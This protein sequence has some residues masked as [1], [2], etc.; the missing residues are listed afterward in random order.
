LANQVTSSSAAANPVNQQQ[1]PVSIVGIVNIAVQGARQDPASLLSFFVIVNIGI[2]LLNM[3]P[4]L[5]LDGGHVAI[6]VYER[7]R[8]RKGKR[9]YADV[10]KLLPVI[11]VFLMMLALL[12]AATLYLDISHP[13][14]L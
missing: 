7:I 5:P 8:S 12:F 10:S 13:L 4:M 1:R 2:G 9:Y 11:Y 3:L 6:A 14:H